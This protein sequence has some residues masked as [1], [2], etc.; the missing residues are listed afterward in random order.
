MWG[1]NKGAWFPLHPTLVALSIVLDRDEDLSRING[2]HPD[3]QQH[4]F[5]DA[6]ADFPPDISDLLPPSAE[7]WWERLGKPQSL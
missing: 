4:E 3:R 5:Y 6:S 1:E 7:R 2:S